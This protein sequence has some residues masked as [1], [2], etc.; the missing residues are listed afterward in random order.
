MNEILEA[1][2]TKDEVKKALFDMDPDK[3]PGPDGFSARFLQVCWPI[4]EKDLLKMVQK[5]QNAQKIG[6]STNSAFL[7]LIP[8][9]KGA[10]NFSRFRPISL[11]NTGYKIITKVIA[12]RLK[13]I[14]PKIIPENQGGF[15]QGRQIVD[16][17]TLVQEA[18]HSSL[19]RKEQGM[20]I[21]L[22]LANDF[23]Q[24]NHSFIL[25]LMSKFGF[26]ANFI[27]WIRA[28]ISEP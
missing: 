21:K 25:K 6:G 14:L 8:K 24:V 12:N 19:L 2:V 11:C 20:V 13:L 4:V 10:N 5:S 26:G 18:I 7:A 15:I 16:N 28:C 9:E 22:D 17:F 27:K 3:A 1:K 23:D